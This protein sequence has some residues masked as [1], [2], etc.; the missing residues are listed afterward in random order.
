MHGR[1]EFYKR[2]IIIIIDFRSI[3]PTAEIFKPKRIQLEALE[4]KRLNTFSVL[5]EARFSREL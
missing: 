3:T 4:P 5:N 1:L 2:Y